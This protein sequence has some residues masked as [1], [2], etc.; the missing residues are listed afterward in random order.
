M[1]FDMICDVAQEVKRKLKMNSLVFTVPA[2]YGGTTES[3]VSA[4]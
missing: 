3:A 2:N 1:A 4:V